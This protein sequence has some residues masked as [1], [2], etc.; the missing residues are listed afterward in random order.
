MAGLPRGFKR[1]LLVGGILA[2]LWGV[3]AD[4]RRRSTLGGEI[5]EKAEGIP[6][7]GARISAALG[8]QFMEG[9]F[10][11]V[12]EDVVAEAKAGELLLLENEPGHLAVEIAHRARDLQITAMDPSAYRVQMA[13]GR[14]HAAGLGRQAKV[15]HGDARDIPFPDGSFDFVVALESFRRSRA[16]ETV[17]GEIHRVLRPGGR[18]WVYDFRQETP[19]EEW[20]RV[21]ERVPLLTRPLFETGIL[22]SWRGAYNEGQIDLYVAGSPFK[23]GTLGV[24]EAEIAGMRVPALTKVTLQK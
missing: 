14:I 12:A 23:Q 17:L 15:V 5:V 10:R 9:V 16:P 2:L 18:A 4:R 22:A 13:E 8:G 24:L 3:L 19:E 11:A 6:F 21:P 7:L 20:E 1:G